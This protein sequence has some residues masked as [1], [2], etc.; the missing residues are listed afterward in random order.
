MNEQIIPTIDEF[1]NQC[2][3]DQK[4]FADNETFEQATEDERGGGDVLPLTFGRSLPDPG[5]PARLLVIFSYGT[6]SLHHERQAPARVQQC[7]DALYAAHP[8]AA[9]VPVRLMVSGF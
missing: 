4:C 6:N 9:A 7:V 1:L 8:E 2:V 3:W 5:D